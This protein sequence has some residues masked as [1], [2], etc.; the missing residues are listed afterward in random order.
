MIPSST[1]QTCGSQ[2]SESVLL[3]RSCHGTPID[4]LRAL[5]KHE[6]AVH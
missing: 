5:I 3:P 2:M 6:L 4:P 1:S